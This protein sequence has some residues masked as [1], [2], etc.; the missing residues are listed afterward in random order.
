MISPIKITLECI[1]SDAFTLEI[2]PEMTMNE[3]ADFLLHCELL[4]QSKQ[5][6]D[7]NIPLRLIS[8]IDSPL[9]NYLLNSPD[10]TVK[11][12]HGVYKY[13]KMK[14]DHACAHLK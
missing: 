7:A 3:L 4:H 12:V 9:L 14:E 10:V 5:V 11:D 13:M 1:F 2:Y 6:E 8:T